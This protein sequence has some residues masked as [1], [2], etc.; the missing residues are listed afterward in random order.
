M[1]RV[2][3]SPLIKGSRV[4]SAADMEEGGGGL[5]TDMKITLG[6]GVY[7]QQMSSTWAW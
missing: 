5:W 3:F 2:F 1:R 4:Q 6:T 7:R